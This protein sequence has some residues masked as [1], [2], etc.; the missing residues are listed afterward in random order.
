MAA[1]MPVEM[2]FDYVGVRL[3]AAKAAGKDIRINFVF[4]DT[5]DTLALSLKNSVV[6]YRKALPAKAD[7]VVTIERGDLHAVLIGRSKLENLVQN[8]RAKVEGDAG[9]LAEILAATTTPEFWFNIVTP[10]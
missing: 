3:D 8:G 4:T 7:A 2:L 5:R 10:N 9:K 1:G 6:N